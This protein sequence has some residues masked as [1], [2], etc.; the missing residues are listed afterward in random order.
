M[1]LCEIEFTSCSSFFLHGCQ[2]QPRGSDEEDIQPESVG[3][4][5]AGALQGRTPIEHNHIRRE[6]PPPEVAVLGMKIEETSTSALVSNYAKLPS[7]A[8]QAVCHLV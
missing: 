4:A 6:H 1:C 2:V 7:A 8:F 3:L 5:G